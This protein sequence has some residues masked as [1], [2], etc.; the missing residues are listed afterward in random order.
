MP[1]HDLS[2]PT[3]TP[4]QCHIDICFSWQPIGLYRLSIHHVSTARLSSIAIRLKFFYWFQIALGCLIGVFTHISWVHLKIHNKHLAIWPSLQRSKSGFLWASPPRRMYAVCGDLL[5]D[6]INSQTQTPC[7]HLAGILL[8]FPSSEFLSH[9]KYVTVQWFGQFNLSILP[10][11]KIISFSQ[12]DNSLKLAVI[13]LSF[14]FKML[15]AIA[16]WALAP[17]QS[18]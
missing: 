13:D 11:N 3:A 6:Q 1:G 8:N 16:I 12:I 7:L 10:V 17:L 4:A 5:S 14:P 15:L 9:L 18:A 2:L